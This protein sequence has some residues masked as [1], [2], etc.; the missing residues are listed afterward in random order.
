MRSEKSTSHLRRAENM[1]E[2]KRVVTEK[3]TSLWR[4]VLG[5]FPKLMDWIAKAQK[6]KTACRQ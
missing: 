3:K 1:S 6:G 5:Y 2:N 4:K